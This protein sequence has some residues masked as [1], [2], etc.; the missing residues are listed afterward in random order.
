MSERYAEYGADSRTLGETGAIA[1]TL[2]IPTVEIRLPRSLADKAL[3]AWQRVDEEALPADETPEQRRLRDDAATL[4]LIG[5]AIE[6]ESCQD[7]EFVIV[8]IAATVLS[9]A[10]DVAD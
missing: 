2:E 10:I 5:A 3:A 6:A 9:R 8:R 7:G 4:A 1:L